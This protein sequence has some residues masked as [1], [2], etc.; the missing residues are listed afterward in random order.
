MVY[1]AL[2]TQFPGQK[3]QQY[4]SHSAT[5]QQDA[6]LVILKKSALFTACS[7]ATHYRRR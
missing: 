6:R 4:Q 3:W 2:A 5:L 1:L 7:A